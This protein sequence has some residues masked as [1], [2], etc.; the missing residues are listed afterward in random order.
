MKMTAG[1]IIE[2]A[3][4]E[5]VEPSAAFITAAEALRWV[6]MAEADFCRRTKILRYYWSYSTVAEQQE[7]PFD[8]DSRF[9]EMLYILCEGEPLIP[10]SLA[11]LDA[12]S[13]TWRYAAGG[14]SEQPKYYYI[15]DVHQLELV[16][17]PCPDA[18][19]T[20]TAYY[21]E[22]PPAISETGTYPKIKDAYHDM[23]IPYVAWRGHLKN[24]N[25]ALAGSAK[26]MYLENVQIANNNLNVRNPERVHVMRGPEYFTSKLRRGNL[27]LP[28]HYGWE[29]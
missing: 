27:A 8:A 21:V 1:Q 25:F 12:Y 16:L 29:R 6:N 5:W 26:K 18:V 7:Y 4:T 19:Y 22:E 23:L 20:I 14:P 13:C 24:R 17:Y 9:Y 10:T 3:R 2:E 11:E 28:D 15:S